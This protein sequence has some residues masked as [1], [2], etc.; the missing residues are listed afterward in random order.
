MKLNIVRKNLDWV[1]RGLP[2]EHDLGGIPG[3][4]TYP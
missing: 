2:K 1:P 4:W 3:S